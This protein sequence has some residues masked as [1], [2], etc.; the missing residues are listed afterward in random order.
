MLISV[1]WRCCT[2]INYRQLQRCAMPHSYS[3]CDPVPSPTRCQPCTSQHT[4]Y[5]L[6]LPPTMWFRDTAH[7]KYLAT[8]TSFWGTSLVHRLVVAARCWRHFL[9]TCISLTV[10][11]TAFQSHSPENW[12]TALHSLSLWPI[13]CILPCVPATHNSRYTCLS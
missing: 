9:L 5:R 12:T 13:T 1:S 6:I 8:R 11:I 2:R 4:F 10:T 3:S 7:R